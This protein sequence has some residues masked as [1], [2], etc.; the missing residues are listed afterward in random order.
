MITPLRC[1]LFQGMIDNSTQRLPVRAELRIEHAA[2]GLVV[3]RLAMPRRCRKRLEIILFRD[4]WSEVGGTLVERCSNPSSSIKHRS[5]ISLSL[6][7]FSLQSDFLSSINNFKILLLHVLSL[8]FCSQVKARKVASTMV[9][10]FCFALP[11]TWRED[12]K[13]VFNPPTDC[14][15][16]NPTRQ[17]SKIDYRFGQYERRIYTVFPPWWTN[18]SGDRARTW[19]RVGVWVR[20]GRRTIVNWSSRCKS[21]NVNVLA[22][23]GYY[24]G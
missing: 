23:C 12:V 5:S 24:Q 6:G 18:A 7:S 1:S 22:R 10:R 20:R 11:Q 15:E 13:F 9:H 14:L 2:R 17:Q 8:Y 19:G 4:E 21:A 16:H 3:S